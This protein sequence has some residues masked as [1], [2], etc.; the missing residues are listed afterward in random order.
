MYLK[1][2]KSTEKGCFGKGDSWINVTCIIC[3]GILY[4]AFLLCGWL[5]LGPY[6][7]KF[8]DPSIA[9]ECLFSLVNGDDM[10]NTYAMMSESSKAAWI[11]SKIYLY[12]FIAL[13]IY[14]VLSVFIS[15]ISDTY[16]TLHEHWR[17]RSKG[18]LQDFATGKLGRAHTHPHHHAHTHSIT[19]IVNEDEDYD[20]LRDITQTAS[21]GT[22]EHTP[23]IV[24]GGPELSKTPPHH[25]HLLTTPPTLRKT[26]QSS[27]N[28]SDNNF[29]EDEGVGPGTEGHAQPVFKL[30]N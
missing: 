19:S 30:D 12:I 3:T 4:I 9:S 11:F 28:N 23:L 24:N 10:F 27:I 15:L 18:L 8:R 17:E 22:L 13:F 2:D 25:Q 14:V 20:L 21:Y 6:H 29:S 26:G 1:I 7:P 16:E 5:V